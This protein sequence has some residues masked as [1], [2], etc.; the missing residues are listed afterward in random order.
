M[1]DRTFL[2]QF[3][4]CTFP[5]DQWNHRA[6]IKV[7]YLYLRRFPLGEAIDRMRSGIQTYNAAN[8]VPEGPN[9]GYHET[10]TQAWMRIIGATIN[11]CG[12]SG[13][14]DSFCDEQPHLLDKRLLLRFYSRDRILSPE[15]KA[16]FIE[17][18]LEPLP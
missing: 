12:S 2:R 13:S 1:D 4:D 17:P 7:A 8:N 10:I 6:H 11:E 3:E 18:D 9:T 15:G 16:G 5:H 14:A